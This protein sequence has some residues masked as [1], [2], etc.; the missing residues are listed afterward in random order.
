MSI[1]LYLSGYDYLAGRVKLVD[2]GKISRL[3]QSSS[4]NVLLAR[5]E[6]LIKDHK[7]LLLEFN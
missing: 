7:K 4:K 5:F 2:Q 3:Q 6:R 1:L